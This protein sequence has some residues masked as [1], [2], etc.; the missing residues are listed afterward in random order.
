MTITDGMRC[1]MRPTSGEPL[2]QLEARNGPH[3]R[4]PS[5]ASSDKEKCHQM[6][7]YK[8]GRRPAYLD[9]LLPGQR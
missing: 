5:F 4:M 8:K 9:S 6:H 7:P 1:T 2:G 3:G